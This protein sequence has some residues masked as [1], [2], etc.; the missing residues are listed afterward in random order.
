MDAVVADFE[1]GAAELLSPMPLQTIGMSSK[2]R[3]HCF[4]R[5]TRLSR[6]VFYTAVNRM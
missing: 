5:P 3:A 6:W 2:D 1:A 4:T